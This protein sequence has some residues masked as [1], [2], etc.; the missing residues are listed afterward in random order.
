MSQ[1]ID[2]EGMERAAR[3][4]HDAAESASRSAER[5]EEAVRRLSVLVDSGYGNN[6]ERLIQLLEK[7]EEEPK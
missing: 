5:F 6:V 1:Y 2:V 4:M 7:Q 3:R